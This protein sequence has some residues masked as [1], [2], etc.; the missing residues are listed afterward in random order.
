[1][2]QNKLVVLSGV[3]L[4]KIIINATNHFDKSLYSRTKVFF[5]GDL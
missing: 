3:Y 2:L 1:M 4:E 5:K